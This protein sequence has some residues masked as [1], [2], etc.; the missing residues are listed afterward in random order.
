MARRRLAPP[1]G[2]LPPYLR[3]YRVRD[4]P[5]DRVGPDDPARPEHLSPAA[6]WAAPL[7]QR[8]AAR[9]LRAWLDWHDGTGADL[10][11]GLRARL[12]ARRAHQ[13]ETWAASR[14]RSLTSPEEGH[15]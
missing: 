3:V 15:R 1:R 7:E 2:A 6:W 8:A 10:I 14:A 11:D 13:H 4:W 9:W 12:A 5:D